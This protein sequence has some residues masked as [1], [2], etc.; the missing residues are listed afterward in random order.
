MQDHRLGHGDRVHFEDRGEG[1]VTFTGSS[2][3]ND[4]HWFGPAAELLDR[5]R[6]LPVEG[7]AEA[8]RDE[9]S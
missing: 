6:K 1:N 2:K 9:F 4:F 5:L 7:G 8:A 3:G